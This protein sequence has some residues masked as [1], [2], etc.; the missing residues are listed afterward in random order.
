MLRCAICGSLFDKNGPLRW[1]HVAKILK[2]KN[3]T[4]QQNKDNGDLQTTW[5]Y[6]AKYG[7]ETWNKFYPEAC[8]S[9]QS[10]I[11]IRTSSAH[12]DATMMKLETHYETE[13]VTIVNNGHSCQIS[14]KKRNSCIKGGPLIY[15]YRLGQL[16]FHWG[17]EGCCGSEHTVNGARF[18]AELH[19]VHW[20]CEKYTS[21]CEAARHPD[22]LAVMGFFLTLEEFSVPRSADKTKF[23]IIS[24]A[25]QHIQFLDEEFNIGPFNPSWIIPADI[26]KFWTY[27]GSLTTPPCTESVTWLVF[28]KPIVISHTQVLL[29]GGSFITLPADILSHP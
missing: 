7:P 29:I 5:D 25:L 11:N 10:P 2:M 26:A 14:F 13:D 24:D 27:Q 23:H 12:F 9:K 20:N 3:E 4:E 1:R 22:G 21:M 16:H 15:K 28:K 19:I 18:P 17:A 6:S 8:G